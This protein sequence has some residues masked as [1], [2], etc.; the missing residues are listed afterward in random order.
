MYSFWEG[1][2]D[3]HV[4]DGSTE[5]RKNRE[6]KEGRREGR[7]RKEG[8]YRCFPFLFLFFSHS[9]S[10]SLNKFMNSSLH[11]TPKQHQI[12]TSSVRAY[13]CIC[14]WARVAS[15]REC[16]G[17]DA[18][19]PS[20]ARRARQAKA[21]LHFLLSVT[22]PSITLDNPTFRPDSRLDLEFRVHVR[23]TLGPEWHL[24]SHVLERLDVLCA[25]G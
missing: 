6:R 9:I 4:L 23:S 20:E 15:E 25:Y 12:V 19:V 5:R 14:V 21:R 16:E 24:P 11:S 2:G 10:I 13:V 17:L 3:R 7:R 18:C 22:A 8:E 1:K